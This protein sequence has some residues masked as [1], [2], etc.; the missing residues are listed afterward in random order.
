MYH[1]ME[2]HRLQVAVRGGQFVLV[3]EPLDR[4]FG[5]ALHH[6]VD[7]LYSTYLLMSHLTEGLGWP[8]T[9]Q[10]IYCIVHTC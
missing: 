6:T 4:G 1:H 9:T 3:D 5:L 2:C 7:V 10:W 8:Y